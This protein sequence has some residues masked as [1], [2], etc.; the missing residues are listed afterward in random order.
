MTRT[1]DALRPALAMSRFGL[2]ARRGRGLDLPG[3]PIDALREEI[4]AGADPLSDN[5]DLAP[6][7][8][9]L[10]QFYA[11]REARK[12]ARESAQQGGAGKASPG[13]RPDM[14]AG[15]PERAGAKDRPEGPPL[16]RRIFLAELEARAEGAWRRPGV[17]FA[18]RMVLFWS[19]HFAVS[20]AKGPVVRVLAGA[21]EREAIRPHVFGRFA[22]MLMT[23]E[24]HP[25]MLVFLDNQRSVGANSPA[26]RGGRNG[27]N[28]N[29]AREIL[30]LHTLGVDGG[31][32]QGDV[33]ALAQAITGWTIVGPQGRMGEPGR[34]MFNPRAHEPG[35]R[36]ILGVRYPASGFGQGRA[37]LLAL[38]RHPA[39]ARHVATKLAR[40]FVAD[41]PP[42]ALVDALAAT[43]R[44]TDGN[45]AAVSET[46]VRHELAWAPERAKVRSPLEFTIALMRATDAQPNGQRLAG[47]LASMG[48]PLWAPPG[49]NGFSDLAPAWASAEGVSARMDVASLVASQAS[50]DDPRALAETLFGP[51]LSAQ[52][53]EAVARAETRQQGLALLFLSPEFQ[54]R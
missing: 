40:H 12:E 39:T 36:T 47:V 54:R 17:G 43:Y 20:A 44:N 5:P 1:D 25:A 8:E 31:Y 48:Q 23:V 9:V 53:R 51:L 50:S 6:S 41:E 42:Q 28:E 26:S 37:A 15:S 21:F 46:L 19:N 38:A 33:T 45:L 18:E 49:P 3:D 2:G 24:T 30:E 7:D 52:T 13:M 14:A 22:D 11:F 29:L 4:R 32:T 10:R 27:L 35:D 34:F 16:P